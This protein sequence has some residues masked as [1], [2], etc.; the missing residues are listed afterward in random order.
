VKHETS[1]VFARGLAVDLQRRRQ[2]VQ[3]LL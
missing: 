2:G 1:S 3:P